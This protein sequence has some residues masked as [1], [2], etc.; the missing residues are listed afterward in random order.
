MKVDGR[1]FRTIWVEPDCRTIGAID[2]RHIY[3]TSPLSFRWSVVISTQMHS[4]FLHARPARPGASGAPAYGAPEQWA[5]KSWGETGPWTDV[6]G[7]ALSMT[8]ALCGYPPIDGEPWVMRRLCL[9][10]KRRPTPR[11][12]GAE[13]PPDV[14]KA[15]EQALALDPRQ[16]F[17]TV[18]AFWTAVEKALRT[19]RAIGAQ[20]AVLILRSALSRASRR[21]AARSCHASILRDAVPRTAPRDEVQ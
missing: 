10:E 2:K 3:L 15:F 16:R 5:P 13:V 6:W 7:L 21:M 14:E 1:H 8:E 19:S 9:D 11:A 20:P 17:K 12:H 18:E 4:S